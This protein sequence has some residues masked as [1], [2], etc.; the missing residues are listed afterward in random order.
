MIIMMLC[1]NFT[2]C[3]LSYLG[4]QDLEVPSDSGQYLISLIAHQGL[5]EVEPL[6]FTCISTSDGA[7]VERAES[8]QVVPVTGLPTA[9]V[10]AAAA[11]G[12]ALSSILPTVS[13][14]TEPDIEF[15]KV[16]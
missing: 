11:T 3:S 8:S 15:L 14:S 13:V 10:A 4:L 12:Q 16:R 5:L 7:R 2:L 6:H 9:A 1:I